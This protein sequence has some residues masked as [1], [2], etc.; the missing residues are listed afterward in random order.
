MLPPNTGDSLSN[1]RN[2]PYI[3]NI[4]EWSVC[5]IAEQGLTWLEADTA[6]HYCHDNHP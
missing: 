6:I 5:L 1:K 2:D 4:W 3:E